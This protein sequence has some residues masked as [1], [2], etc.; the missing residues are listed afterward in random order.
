[1][2]AAG[3]SPRRP[4]PDYTQRSVKLRLFLYLAAIML[5]AGVIERIRDPAA[6]QGLANLDHRAVP[7]EPFNN[8]LADR[9]L[10]T[11]ADPAEPFRGRG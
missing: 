2:A 10:R 7:Q 6:R 1:M 9:G 8:R 11:A 5:V 4:P 3:P